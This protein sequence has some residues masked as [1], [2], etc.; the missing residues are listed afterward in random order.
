MKPFGYLRKLRGIFIF[1]LVWMGVPRT[2]HFWT[3]AEGW[4]FL[5]FITW[6][7]ALLIVNYF[8]DED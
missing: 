7:P 1:F 6:L 4:Y 3:G 2:M 8:E 5:I